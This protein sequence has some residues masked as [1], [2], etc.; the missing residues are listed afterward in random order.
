MIKKGNDYDQ[1][2]KRKSGVNDTFVVS[3]YSVFFFLSTFEICKKPQFCTNKFCSEM[4]ERMFA[5][6]KFYI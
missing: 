5:I 2:K 1:T 6:F 3:T 4:K